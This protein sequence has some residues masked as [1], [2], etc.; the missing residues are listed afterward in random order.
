MVM[1]ETDMALSQHSVIDVRALIEQVIKSSGLIIVLAVLFGLLAFIFAV[2]PIP[3][4]VH[5]TLNV[6]PASSGA[7]E[8]SA[9]TNMDTELGRINSWTTVE[10]VLNK[11]SRYGIVSLK[12][13]PDMP[14]TLQRVKNFILTGKKHEERDELP[15]HL[16][17]MNFPSALN[18]QSLQ[19]HITGKDTYSVENSKGEKLFDSKVGER[20]K[21]GGDY[22][23]YITEVNAPVGSIFNLIPKSKEA[24][25]EMVLSSLRVTK[26]TANKGS[27]LVDLHF[28]SKDSYFAIKLVEAIVN[29]YVEQSEQRILSSKENAVDELAKELELVRK[30]LDVAED[31]LGEYM[32]GI[33]VA[34]VDAEMRGQLELRLSLEQSLRQVQLQKAQLRQVYT[35]GHP[36]MKAAN[37]KEAQLKAKLAKVHERLSL[38]PE[39][40]GKLFTL[41]RKVKQYASQYTAVLEQYTQLKIDTS[42]VSNYASIVNLPRIVR[43]N[44]RNKS[45]QIVIL[46]M[47]MG[48]IVALSFIILNSNLRANILKN[49]NQLSEFDTLSITDLDPDAITKKCPDK[50]DGGCNVIDELV[51]QFSYL[52]SQK[53]NNITVITADKTTPKKSEI[54]LQLARQVAQST[55]KV[56]LIDANVRASHLAGYVGLDGEAG[57]ANAMAGSAPS[58]DIIH[59][60]DRSNLYY[61]PP[62]NPA[63]SIQILRDF[64]RFDYLLA[65]FGKLFDRIIVDLPSQR[66]LPFW[67]GMIT[68]TGTSLHFVEKGGHIENAMQYIH[69]VSELSKVSPETLH[70]I[71]LYAKQ[72]NAKHG[73]LDKILALFKSR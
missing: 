52:A 70:E 34:D 33:D 49:V 22:E 67:Q 25:T 39:I 73:L 17:F 27:S 2:R 24:M 6:D 20:G 72:D 38:L 28:F 16:D 43:R 10:R 18:G 5:A 53:K 1:Q 21:K 32:K 58:K 45:I 29:D 35:K 12:Y 11:M 65:E 4:E 63:M 46:G 47:I 19:L 8:L 9:G 56:L 54:S 37:E 64:K 36:A 48:V 51:A 14:S 71:L 69:T 30:Q 23:L 60:V 40:K 41:N 31:K 57:F 42:S 66:E 44:L 61:M 3:Y 13:S 55:G 26:R 62:G 68:R 7:L 50:M 15:I 59:R